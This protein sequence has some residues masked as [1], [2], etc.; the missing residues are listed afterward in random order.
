[1]TAPASHS[2]PI[3][4]LHSD[5]RL[6]APQRLQTA[7]APTVQLAGAASGTCGPRLLSVRNCSGTSRDSSMSMRPTRRRGSFTRDEDHGHGP[8]SPRARAERYQLTPRVR[9]PP[10][11]RMGADPWRAG[12][13][14]RLGEADRVRRPQGGLGAVAGSRTMGCQEDGY[15][16]CRPAQ[17]VSLLITGAGRCGPACARRAVPRLSLALTPGPAPHSGAA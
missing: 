16:Q 1:M 2:Q 5:R 11:F 7:L 10:V 3:A 9:S 14:P 15:V 4:A 6:K 8:G 13:G 17:Q 12:A